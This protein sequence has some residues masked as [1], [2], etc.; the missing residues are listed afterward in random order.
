MCFEF[1][2]RKSKCAFVFTSLLTLFLSYS[3][4]SAQV[5]FGYGESGGE[6]L[7]QL[8]GTANCFCTCKK[9]NPG[10]Q[11]DHEEEQEFN[12][13]SEEECLEQEGRACVGDATGPGDFRGELEDCEYAVEEEDPESLI[14]P[15]F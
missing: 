11:L 12:A 15:L 4:A 13:D 5:S 2:Q 8:S 14:Y 1:Y 9:D 10:S 3:P 7:F 6:S